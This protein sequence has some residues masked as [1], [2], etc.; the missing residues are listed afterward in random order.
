MIAAIGISLAI[1]CVIACEL[2]GY[3]LARAHWRWL[4]NQGG[5]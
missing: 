4:N 2:G 5:E 1:L 3:R